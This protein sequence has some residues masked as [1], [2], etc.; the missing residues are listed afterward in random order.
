MT[1]GSY[2]DIRAA[3]EIVAV[4]EGSNHGWPSCVDDNRPVVE[5]GVVDP[6]AGVPN[7][8]AILGVGATPT[9]LA[10]APWDRTQLVVALWVEQRLVT[11]S[12]DPADAGA[13]PEPLDLVFD[14]P[15]HLVADGDRLLV[16]DHGAGSIVA[17]TRNVT[18]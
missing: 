15:Q 8:Q 11:V 12:L 14:R 7:S 10:V 2:D 4:A 17:V 6:C 5:S 13:A 3:D 1:D 18:G 9:G 16:T